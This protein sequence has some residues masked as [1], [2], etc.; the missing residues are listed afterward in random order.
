MLKIEFD[1]VNHPFFYC[2]KSMEK[3]KT[4]TIENITIEHKKT[5]FITPLNL[6]AMFRHS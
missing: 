3:I 2:R 6:W 1:C 5:N 4:M